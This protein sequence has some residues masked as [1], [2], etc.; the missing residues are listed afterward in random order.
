M[1]L[2]KVVEHFGSQTAL[3]RAL[4]IKQPSVAEWFERGIPIPRQY[5]IQVITDGAFK[6]SSAPVTPS[7]VS[8]PSN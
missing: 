4:G 3:A 8:A 6:V 1:E 5:Q 2:R 7:G